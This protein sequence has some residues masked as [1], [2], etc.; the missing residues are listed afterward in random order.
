M[1]FNTISSGDFDTFSVVAT[2]A[3]TVAKCLLKLWLDDE[4]EECINGLVL[5][6]DPND[7][8]DDGVDFEDGLCAFLMVDVSLGLMVLLM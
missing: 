2:E 5:N 3:E 7:K 4:T 8:K 6:L 1:G